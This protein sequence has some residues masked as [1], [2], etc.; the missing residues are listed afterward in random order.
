MYMA[1]SDKTVL[2]VEDEKELLESYQEIIETAGY[3]VIGV[4]DGYQALDV[5]GKRHKEVDLILL[6]LMMLGVDGLEVLKAI[7]ADKEKYGEAPVIILTNM[8]SESVIRESFN[9][10]ASSYLVKA[11]LDYQG[12]TKELERYLGD[13]GSL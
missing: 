10:G 5:L 9:L 6:D 11:D 12:L 7:R 8:T 13:E 4:T 2:V 1:K 3:N